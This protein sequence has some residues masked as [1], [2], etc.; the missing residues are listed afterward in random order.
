[1][2]LEQVFDLQGLD[3]PGK[4]GALLKQVFGGNPQPESQILLHR[5]VREKGQI[6]G[7]VGDPPLFRRQL[8]DFFFA[9]KDLP[10]GS[11]LNLRW[12]QDEVFPPRRPQ[13]HVEKPLPSR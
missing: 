3:Q 13:E 7:N 10:R 4:V 9:D 8:L 5:E 2:A 11:S 12:I 1:V 6:L